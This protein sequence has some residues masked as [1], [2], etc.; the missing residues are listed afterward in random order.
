[1]VLGLLC[2]PVS[3]GRAGSM[4]EGF[5][6]LRSVDPTIEQDI[7]YAGPDNFTGRPVPGYGAAECVLVEGAAQALRRVQA[8][9]AAN[10]HGLKVFDCYRP[11]QAVSAFLDWAKKPAVP[12]LKRA[13]HPR[14]PKSG[15]FPTYIARRSGHSRG[16]A[17]DL[18]L[19][20][21][22]PAPAQPSPTSSI[23]GRPGELKSPRSELDMGTG[24][25]CFDRQSRTNAPEIG[26]SQLKN[27]TLLVRMM[28][29]HGF[30]NYAGEWWHFS[31]HPEPY[32]ETYF[33]FAIPP[34][35][36]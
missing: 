9:L 7:R 13:Y 8:A 35:P 26:K 29:Q 30:R 34:A 28:R 22:S 14:I 20:H 11:A 3:P 2:A 4:P 25:D 27:R 33:D 10:G 36:R 16:A 6:H 19:V 24:F 32:P 18:T 15:L 5:V 21:L 17:V 23:C 12:K 1:L 31:F